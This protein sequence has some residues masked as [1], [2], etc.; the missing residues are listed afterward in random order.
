MRLAIQ[1]PCFN[2]AEQL[3]ATLRDLPKHVDGVD[4]ILVVVIDD[5]STDA[6]CQIAAEFGV[7]R[8]IC[9]SVN[10]G[11]SE[12]FSSGLDACLA[13]GADIIVNTDADGQYPGDAIERLIDPIR[14]RRADIV[15]G[16][17]NPG[18]NGEFSWFKRRL[19]C[20]GSLIVGLL[21][22]QPIPDAV[23]GFRA[24]SRTAAIRI[25]LLTRFSHTI[26][27]ILQ[28]SHHRLA[29]EFVPIEVA[30][31]VRPSRLASSSLTFV[32]RQ[33]VTILGMT[34]LYRPKWLFAPPALLLIA[35][36]GLP[37]FR[38]LVLWSFGN[39]DGHLQ[40]LVLAGVCV[41]ASL[42]LFGLWALAELIVFV[43]R[44]LE[45]ILQTVREQRYRPSTSSSITLDCE[46]IGIDSLR[47]LRM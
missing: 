12:A 33:A 30:R 2:E 34:L 18:T 22:R 19:Q 42:G 5:G 31:S 40:S 4:E 17:R 10:R 16:D 15:I 32:F 36:G 1:I 13:L 38:F 41:L 28:A 43:R 21:A 39:G 11:L 7:S 35:I 47:V 9:H 24:F 25:C 27:T 37:I 3:F 14:C 8:V 46:G 45:E 23:S 6:T 26:E 20:Y 44:L 29:I